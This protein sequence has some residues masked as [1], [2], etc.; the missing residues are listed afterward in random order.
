MTMLARASVDAAFDY[1]QLHYGRRQ[2][3]PEA[4]ARYAIYKPSSRAGW[5][6]VHRDSGDV[7]TAEDAPGLLRKLRDDSGRRADQRNNDNRKTGT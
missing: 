3:A 5:I 6:A 2:D 1:F 7:L 4:E